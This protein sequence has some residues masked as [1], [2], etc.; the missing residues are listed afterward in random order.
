M[1]A[2]VRGLPFLL[3]VL[4]LLC[5]PRVPYAQVA[6][7][8]VIPFESMT[9]TDEQFLAGS[10][11]GKRV[12]IAG[13]LR[14]PRPG[15][16]RLPAVILLH[17]SGGIGGQIADWEQ[18][19]LS[20]G[21]ATFVVDSFTSR[22]IENT[23]NDQSQLGRLAQTEDAYRA[24]S[25]ISKNPHVDASRVMLMGFSRGGQDTLYASMVRF[26]KA[27]A[28]AS[29]PGFAAYVPLY[30]DCSAHYLDDD[31]VS[32]APIRIFHGSA[33]NYD[34]VAPCKAYVERLKAKGADVE[35][36]EFA[37]VNH[38]FDARAFAHPT[39]LP[40]AQTV[41]N[42]AW[43]EHSAGHLLNVKSNLPFS[44]ADPCVERGV[45]IGYDESATEQTKKAIANL[46]T[47][48]LKPTPT[49]AP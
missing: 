13:E 14:L 15:T 44:Y 40:K 12:T 24:L 19:F 18:W 35:L 8:E 36:T 5:I 30:P 49:R 48:T 38:I 6:R 33:D 34:P 26:Q 25:L 7:I 4:V 20:L 22:G 39:S 46:V 11:D 32:K 47:T 37:G 23:I 29:S 3:L 43:E 27:H 41:R 42:C 10:E 21:V 9:L 45:T 16:D 28:D 31:N 17:P 1:F 2:S